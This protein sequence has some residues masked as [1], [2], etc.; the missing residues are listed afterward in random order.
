MDLKD[1]AK[2]FGLTVR[3]LAEVLGYTTQGLYISTRRPPGNG[4]NRR[5][6]ALQILEFRSQ[7]EYQKDLQMA[8]VKRIEREKA[9]EELAI[10]FQIHHRNSRSCDRFKCND[11][12]NCNG[13]VCATCE[14]H[15]CEFCRHFEMCLEQGKLPI[16]EEE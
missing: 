16:K 1:V 8:E 4:S 15:R 13:D 6:L 10:I 5:K 7:V 14:Y 3:G 11:A 9:I 2:T 12:P